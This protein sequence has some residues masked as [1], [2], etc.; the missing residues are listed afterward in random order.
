M[1]GKTSVLALALWASAAQAEIV[2]E[3]F[4]PAGLIPPE[5][6]SYIGVPILPPA[7]QRVGQTFTI[8]HSGKLLS[9]EMLLS[10]YP[11][12]QYPDF[13]VVIYDAP[14]G[15]E[16]A[17]KT[18]SVPGTISA[19]QQWFGVDL[20]SQNLLV[21]AGATLFLT[22]EGLGQPEGSVVSWFGWRAP[23]HILYADGDALIF[24]PCHPLGGSAGCGQWA[25]L[26]LDEDGNGASLSYRIRIDTS[27]QNSAVPE[28]A[29]WAMMI[30]GFGLAGTALRRRQ[31][32]VVKG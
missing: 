1:I 19:Y 26:P 29:S 24:Q 31:I 32:D 16:L 30:A 23:D 5:V 6:T 9:A 21:D 13:D 15:N 8:G 28:P 25:P 7:S 10:G 4:P 3:R 12:F 17:R 14:A 20:S 11:G 22:L 18:M 27:V 2:T